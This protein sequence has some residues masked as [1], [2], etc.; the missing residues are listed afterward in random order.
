MSK[1]SNIRTH[2]FSIQVNTYTRTEFSEKK[3]LQNKEM[4]CKNVKIANRIC[5]YVV[6]IDS[7][8]VNQLFSADKYAEIRILYMI[9]QY[10][11]IPKKPQK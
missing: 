3:L 8:R 4:M 1:L 10:K 11:N 9:C 2:P 7:L 6:I 5:M